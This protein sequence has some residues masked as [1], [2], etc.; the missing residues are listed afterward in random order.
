MDL[1]MHLWMLKNIIWTSICGRVRKHVTR[2]YMCINIYIYIHVRVCVNMCL[3]IYGHLLL[4][5][6]IYLFMY[7]FGFVHI[8]VFKS[9]YSN[10]FKTTFL[11]LYLSIC[12]FT[13]LFVCLFTYLIFYS[14]I[15][16]S[17]VNRYSSTVNTYQIEMLRDRDVE[18]CWEA[19]I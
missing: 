11:R 12:L 10:L 16:L 13:Y 7:L 15:C 18:R 9:M 1:C 19:R 5:L 8:Y 4:H 6:C 3:F 2:T 14:F 17:S